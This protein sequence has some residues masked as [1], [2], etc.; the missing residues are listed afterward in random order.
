MNREL[1]SMLR[2]ALPVVVAELGWITMGIVDTIFVGPLGPAAIGAVGTGST[3]F[4]TVMVL[5]MGTLLALDTFVAQ[6]YGAGRVDEC[7]RWLFAGLQ[8]GG[9][10]V[11]RARRDRAR[12]RVAARSRRDSSGRHRAA[13][14]VPQN[15]DVVGAAAARVHGVPA[16][17]AGHELRA[18]DD[19]RAAGGE[20]HQRG[21]QLDLHLRPPRD[22]GAWRAG[23]GVRHARGARVSARSPCSS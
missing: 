18:A 20:S 3:M 17:S 19:G 6:S 22:A 11:G 15:A 14:A 8:L 13:A 5:G 16:L 4:F 21:G 2:L 23:I 7:H 12:G 9:R 10:A 1:S